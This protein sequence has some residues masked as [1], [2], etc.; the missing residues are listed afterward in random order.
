VCITT[1]FAAATAAA[2]APDSANPRNFLSKSTASTYLLTL[3][4]FVEV[5]EA[6]V[7]VVDDEVLVFEDIVIPE[8]AKKSDTV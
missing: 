2:L 4:K 5:E 3:N 1:S 6:E 8:L 7:V